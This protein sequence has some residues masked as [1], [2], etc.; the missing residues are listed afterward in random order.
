MY[1]R[2]ETTQN[3]LDRALD[4]TLTTRPIDARWEAWW[5]S[6]AMYGAGPATLP[7]L[8]AAQS[9]REV[10]EELV[11]PP[12]RSGRFVERDTTGIVVGVP[13]CT[14]NFRHLIAIAAVLDFLARSTQATGGHV[15][16]FDAM[17][18]SDDVML[19]AT[20]DASGLHPT[21]ASTLGQVNADVVQVASERI[22]RRLD[23]LAP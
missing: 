23:E 21:T 17:W 11:D 20:L 2:L 16:V 8:G 1:L 13:L 10:W 12:E 7:P 9:A 19:F 18:G 15:L 4:A 5:D 14:E 3:A 6:R 22:S